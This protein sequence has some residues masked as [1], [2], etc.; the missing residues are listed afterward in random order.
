VP[1]GFQLVVACQPA[2]VKRFAA[3]AID[4]IP[5]CLTA[6]LLELEQFRRLFFR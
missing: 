6:F 2:P 4:R 3:A 1:D 5:D